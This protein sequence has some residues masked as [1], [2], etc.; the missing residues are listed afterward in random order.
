MRC[1][2]R[3]RQHDAKRPL[4]DEGHYLFG[5]LGAPGFKQYWTVQHQNSQDGLYPIIDLLWVFPL[6]PSCRKFASDVRYRSRWTPVPVL[7]ISTS[8]AR[9]R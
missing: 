3:K 9:Y 4:D 6:A 8:G 1:C 2:L 5:P 7:V